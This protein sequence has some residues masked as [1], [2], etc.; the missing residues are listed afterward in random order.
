MSSIAELLIAA[1]LTLTN[2]SEAKLDSQI[3]LAHVIGKNTSYLLTWPDKIIEPKL[4]NKFLEYVER[5]KT[6]EPVAYITGVQCFWDLS[7]KVDHNTLIPRPDT[8]TL[9]EQSLNLIR[10]NNYK[11]IIDLGTGSGAVAL[12]LAKEYKYLEVLATDISIKA[13]EVASENAKLNNIK[14]IK[15]ILSNWFDDIKSNSGLNNT[16][17]DLIISNPPYIANNDDHLQYLQFEPIGALVSG[18]DGLD[19]IRKICNQASMYLNINGSLIFEHGFNQA[20]EVTNIL[21]DNGFKNCQTV[22]D[23]AGIPRVTCAVWQG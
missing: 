4:E 18:D 21:G 13:L 1:E 11:K 15:F 17:F 3:L 23:L 10:Q 19:D 14:N 20:D 9:V 6:G 12:S 22:L 16:K 7:L 5:R 2:N 8:E